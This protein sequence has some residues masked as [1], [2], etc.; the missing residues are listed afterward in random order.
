MYMREGWRVGTRERGAHLLAKLLVLLV[1]RVQPLLLRATGLVR[2]ERG[3]LWRLEREAVSRRAD[4]HAHHRRRAA[5]RRAL[6]RAPSARPAP[7]SRA[8]AHAAQDVLRAVIMREREVP[9]REHVGVQAHLVLLE[10]GHFVP[11]V[12]G[13]IP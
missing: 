11:Y 1:H 5:A 9:Q 3:L 13:I 12:P 8:F 6:A 4:P 10:V 2:N 7:G